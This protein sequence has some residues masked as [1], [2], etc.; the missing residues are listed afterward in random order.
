MNR[1]VSKN[2]LMDELR[3]IISEVCEVEKALIAEDTDFINDLNINSLMALEVIVSLEKKYKFK[4]NEREITKARSLRDIY[5]LTVH[6][7]GSDK[8]IEAV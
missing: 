7:I 2:G 4:L 3:D 8:I 5:D 6:K 1:K